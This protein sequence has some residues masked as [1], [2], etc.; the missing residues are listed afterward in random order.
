MTGYVVVVVRRR[1]RH[2]RDYRRRF[3]VLLIH[4]VVS[5][6]HDHPA[7][8]CARFAAFPLRRSLD[9]KTAALR[10][11][12]QTLVFF[13]FLFVSSAHFQRPRRQL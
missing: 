5:P 9:S 3:L 4:R 12:F 10:F 8:H 7:L 6:F 13:S 2:R 11:Q 1:R